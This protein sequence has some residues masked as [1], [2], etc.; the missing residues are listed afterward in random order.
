MNELALQLADEAERVLAGLCSTEAVKAADRG[1]WAERLWQAVESSGLHR[2]CL[3]EAQGGAELRL[4]AVLPLV[5]R[6]ARNAAPVPFA[7]T[8]LATTLLARSGVEVPAGLL[9]LCDAPAA[10]GP[11]P[12]QVRVP[13]GRYAGQVLV[14]QEDGSATRLS[15]LDAA[16]LSVVPGV[17]LAGEPLDLLSI[18]RGDAAIRAQASLDMPA[19]AVR[20]WGALLRAAQLAAAMERVLE[21][22]VEHANTRVQ[23]GRSI[24]SFQAIQHSLVLAY[25]ECAAAAAAVEAAAALSETA[26]HPLAVPVAK[27]RC[28]RAGAVVARVAHQVLGAMGYTHEHALHQFT[29]RLWSWRDDFGSEGEWA[30]RL[31]AEARRHGA[32]RDGLWD[33]ITARGQA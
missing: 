8:L 29:R 22:A 15:L 2:A 14:W 10:G 7:D 6:F 19:E 9:T 25:G 11:L 5:Q 28:G 32:R 16:A 23:F 27:V 30:R 13:Y 26:P 31:G 20:A 24:G 21:L 12:E 33:W 1:G 3:P 17:N 18:P 4:S